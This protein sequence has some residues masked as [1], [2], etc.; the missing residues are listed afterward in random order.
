VKVERARGPSPSRPLVEER[1]ITGGGDAATN[2][3]L[4]GSDTGE[5]CLQ[6]ESRHRCRGVAGEIRTSNLL[7]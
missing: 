6:S 1:P 5:I 2:F 4:E 3:R 7:L